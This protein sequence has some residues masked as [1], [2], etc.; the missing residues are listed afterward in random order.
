MMYL[1]FSCTLQCLEIYQGIFINLGFGLLHTTN[2]DEMSKRNKG[3]HLKLCFL[4]IYIGFKLYKISPNYH[5]RGDLIN[6]P[7]FYFIGVLEAISMDKH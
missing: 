3:L 1:Y 4:K 5:P 2:D 7:C 6:H